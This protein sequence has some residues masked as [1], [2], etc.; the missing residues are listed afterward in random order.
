VRDILALVDETVGNWL[1]LRGADVHLET[2]WAASAVLVVL[3][4]SSLLV[5]LVRWVGS[6]PPERAHLALPALLPVMRRPRFSVVRHGA[7]LVF[8]LGLPFFAL[9]LAD[10]RT[11][12]S[13]EETSYPGRRIA[14]L[15]D[16]SASM[17]L[18]FDT[19][20]LKVPDNRAFYTAVAAAE[21][22]ME[23]R[24]R[25]RYRDLIALIQFG[26]EAYVV[27]PFTTDYENIQL[28]I[29]LISNP[30]EWG[31]FSD[32]GTTILRGVGEGINLFKSFEFTNAAGNL[33]VMFTDGRDNE[34]DIQGA[35]VNAVVAELRQHRIP[36]YMIRTAFNFGEGKIPQDR[37]WKALV[38]QT[39]GRFYA[40]DSEDAIMRAVAE[41][42]KR[43]AGRIEVREYTA[44]RP[45]FEGYALV[46]VGL[47][48][49]AVV[50]KLGVR[51]FR[52]F[53]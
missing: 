50:M 23:L 13:R 24:R 31:G 17:I 8:L 47:W 12:F 38:E 48:F 9:A 3:V 16:A 15:V 1:R 53:P 20:K 6:R 2:A 25:G 41:I 27:T 32:F 42:D 30:R 28:S 35:S 40:A 33:M 34:R 39:G 21:H 36:L 46:A 11:E 49:L 14:L 43:S 29:R 44:Q 7:F 18:K 19:A 52:T 45:R 4:T 22:F 5:L 26:N 37:L 51:S 10:P